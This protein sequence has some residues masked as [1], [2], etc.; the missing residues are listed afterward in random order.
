MKRFLVIF[1]ILF[2]LLPLSACNK[3][4]NT[5]TTPNDVS[6]ND[7]ASKVV[8]TDPM[9]PNDD[10]KMY[11]IGDTAISTNWKFTLKNFYFTTSLNMSQYDISGFLTENGDKKD[12]ICYAEDGKA[13]AVL[14]YDVDYLGTSEEEVK[15]R[16]NIT[17][18]YKETESYREALP[19]SSANITE[20]FYVKKPPVFEGD[21]D[22]YFE[23]AQYTRFDGETE[24]KEIRAYFVVPKEV[25]EADTE[26]STLSVR[27][28]GNEY[29]YSIQ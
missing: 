12:D 3:P 8:E 10:V 14:V 6:K 18:K 5:E 15:Y 21:D 11:S 29:L 17:L 23:A 16:Q 9:K 7:D 22:W 20:Y 27:L 13:F 25:M 4:S 19:T 28:D 24:P 2:L 26:A 1:M